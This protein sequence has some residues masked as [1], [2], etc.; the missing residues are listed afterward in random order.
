MFLSAPLH[1]PAYGFMANAGNDFLI[2]CTLKGSVVFIA[3]VI[4][5]QPAD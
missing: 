1:Q 2:P 4:K 3:A 5:R